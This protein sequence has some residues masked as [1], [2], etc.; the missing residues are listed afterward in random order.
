MPVFTIQTPE[1]RTLKIEAA[2]QAAAIRGAREWSAKNGGGKP[3]SSGKPKGYD[4][5]R[6]RLAQQEAA[7]RAANER[8]AGPLGGLLNA[9]GDF[10]AQ[11]VRNIGAADEVAG[12]VNFG[13]QGLENLVRR[14]RGQ[15]ITVPAATAY[16]AAADQEREQQAEYARAY[17]GRNAGASVVGALVSGRPTGGATFTNPLKAGAAAAVQNAPF[18]VARQEGNLAERLPGAAKETAVVGTLGTA[19]A[20]LGNLASRSASKAKAAPLTA[21]RKLSREGVELTPGQMLGGGA[22]RL[23]DAMTSVPGV[24]DAIRGAKVRGLESFDRAAINRTL[25]PLGEVMPDNVNVGRDG[26]RYAQDV[27]SGAYDDALRGVTITPD[28]EFVAALRGIRNQEGLSTGAA[29]EVG[30]IV[31][32]VFRQL[33]VTFDEKGALKLV[34]ESIDGPTFKMLDA[35]I[36]AAARA[37][38][39]AARTQPSMARA[40]MALNEIGDAMDNLLGRTDFAALAGK[41][42]A[43]EAFANLIRVQ[44]AAAGAGAREGIFSAPQLSAAVRQADTGRKAAFARGDALM[45]DLTDAGVAVLP[46]TVPDSGTPLRSLVSGLGITGGGLTLGVP[47]EAAAVAGTGVAA[48]M[49][50]YSKPVLDLVNR[51]YRASSPGQQRQL[52]ARLAALAS[53]NPA[54]GQ[55]YDQVKREMSASERPVAVAQ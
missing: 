21:A 16:R 39:N 24:G 22:Q 33:G 3:Q 12:A 31:S 43:D 42:A 37:A 10:Q 52:L 27:I 50:L 1:G 11:I 26:I 34:K 49:G 23:E 17:P 8:F 28:D 25:A 15:D 4:A 20:G 7:R 35:D 30:A 5:A 2:D 55:L 9:S 38:A 47:L 53:E 18:A 32:D 45:Q 29:D 44:G 46:P 36:G 19:V 6:S 51:I 41:R 54:L 48:G 13:V 14:A 40:A